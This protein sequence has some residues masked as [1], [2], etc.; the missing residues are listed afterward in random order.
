M[1]QKGSAA[2]IVHTEW[3]IALLHKKCRKSGQRKSWEQDL[4]GRKLYTFV[5]KSV[6]GGF[7][8]EVACLFVMLTWH[9]PNQPHEPEFP[10]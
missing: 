4:Q 1:F 2:E 7:K 5:S 3:D 9:N 10:H 8:E 6:S